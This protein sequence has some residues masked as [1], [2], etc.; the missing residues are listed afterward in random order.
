MIL[1]VT[2]AQVSGP[3]HLTVTFNS[4]VRKRVNLVPLLHGPAFERL[5]DPEYFAQAE[6]DTE[7]GVVTWPNEEDVAPEALLALP[8]ES[9][10][11]EGQLTR[12][13][14]RG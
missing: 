8:D 5:L 10:E 13:Q 4:G 14:A 1:H 9:S 3:T 12:K 11:N 7:L 2:A 6:L